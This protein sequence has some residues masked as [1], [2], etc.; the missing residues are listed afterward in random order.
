MVRSIL[1][2]LITGYWL[3]QE[4]GFDPTQRVLEAISEYRQEADVIGVFL[5]ESTVECEKNRLST[6]A[7]YTHYALWAKDNG[8]KPLNNRNFVIELRRRCDVRKD[9]D[10][11][12]VVGLALSFGTELPD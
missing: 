6:S 9:R 5:A 11:N 8:Y 7:L 12:V 4:V 1:N 10:C 2:W 3:I